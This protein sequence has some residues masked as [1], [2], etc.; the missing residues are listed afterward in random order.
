MGR[1]ILFSPVGGTDPISQD[2]IYDGALIHICRWFDIDVVYLYMSK[3][4]VDLHNKDNRYMYCLDKLSEMKGEKIEVHCIERK[5]LEKV[6]QFDYFYED[7]QKCIGDIAKNIKDDDKILLNV[8]S[9]TPAMK[10]G[11]LVLATLG[12]Y[13][14]KLIQVATPTHKMNNH[15]HDNYDVELLWELNADNENDSVNRCSEITCPSLSIIKQ[16][17]IIKQLVR[18][19]NYKAAIMAAD[20]L[21][22]DVVDKYYEILEIAYY[23]TQLDRIRIIPLKKKYDIEGFPIKDDKVVDCFEYALSLDVKRRRGEYADFVRAISPLIVDL[24]ILILKNEICEDVLKYMNTDSHKALKWDKNKL[25]NTDIKSILMNRWYNFNLNG[26]VSAVHLLEVIN[27]KS[28]DSKLIGVVEGLRNVEERVRNI[29]AHQIVS[30]TDNTIKKYTGYNS[31]DVIELIKK[32]F[33][34]TGI[35]IKKEYWN[36]YD[37]MNEYIIKKIEGV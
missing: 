29:A 25:E 7:F 11:L 19:Y 3:E 8:S 24:Y 32:A 18:D 22:K 9:G 36:A 17:E 2:N 16:E 37:D 5:N 27:N 26:V 23:R 12:E 31:N 30:I 35:N 34:Y 28:N 20:R 10:S 21:P 4:I 33:R 6:H 13:N 14:Y 15:N 1:K